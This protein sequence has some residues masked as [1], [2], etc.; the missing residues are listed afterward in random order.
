M[1]T[2][3]LDQNRI[4][5]KITD[6]HSKLFYSGILIR[7]S[8]E[9]RVHCGPHVREG[10]TRRRER[11]CAEVGTFSVHSPL[12]QHRFV[13]ICIDET[14]HISCVHSLTTLGGN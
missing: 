8:I 6:H 7:G 10:P 4:L 12:Y 5:I 1:R 11:T 2:S 14:M 13:L 3:N 9:M